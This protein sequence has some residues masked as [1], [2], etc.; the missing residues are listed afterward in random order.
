L[1]GAALAF[2]A[3]A[4]ATFPGK[5]GR[6]AFF[7]YSSG[8]ETI[9]P[10][11]SDRTVLGAGW[12]PSWSPDGGRIAFSDYKDIWAMNADG[13]GRTR[14]I[15]SPWPVFCDLH[16]SGR[17]LISP[18]WSPNSAK[19]VFV[20]L[21]DCE[22]TDYCPDPDLFTANAN[23]TA[24]VQLT[25]AIGELGCCG[26]T[27]DWSP[28]G[29][30]ISYLGGTFCDPYC[31]ALFT[32][33]PDGSDVREI[34]DGYSPSWSPDG[35]KIAVSA[36]GEIYTINAD[37]SGP[38]K[39][40]N[41]AVTGNA[42]GPVWSPDGTKI[43][44]SAGPASSPGDIYVMNAD[45]SNQ[46]RIT[47]TPDIGEGNLDWQ[48]IPYGYARPLSATPA[49]VKLVPASKACTR[50]NSLHGSPL[51]VASCN[52]P[53]QAS[54]YLTIG[55]PDVN[56]KAA[57]STGT[58]SMRVRSCP[59]CASP[60][61]TDV[62]L[63]ATLTDIRKKSD[64]SDYTGELQ[65][66][67]NLRVTDRYSGPSLNLPATA[68]DSPLSF[69]MTCTATTEATGSTCSANTSANAILPGIVRDYQRA[70]WELG[71][72]KV[73]DGGSD[74]DADTTGDNTLFEVQGLYAP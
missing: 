25:P 38:V 1:V 17:S 64:L 41:F 33:R 55:T 4:H 57:S 22:G 24:V 70:V 61:G 2:P 16:C 32:I 13:T 35:K 21:G 72:V 54:T 44:F 67:L 66:V 63:T 50:S 74:G 34:F 56:G 23:G 69:P 46:T 27:P 37:G 42:C 14:I 28:D 12:D 18:A 10:D 20:A 62:L 59:A 30:R 26:D 29:S 53:A 65:T 19:L 45:G 15:P 51:A 6:I 52:P 5:N 3:A 68:A 31:S 39:L 60:M 11:G 73:Y 8:I 40:T 43:A 71:Q 36:S 48:P 9:A 58:I 7:T 49:T 47:N